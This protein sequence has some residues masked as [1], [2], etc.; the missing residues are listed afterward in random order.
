MI[1]EIES[2]RPSCRPSLDY[3]EGKVLR[4]VAELVGY[5]NMDGTDRDAVYALFERF[6]RTR[7]AVR[8]MSFH[9]SVNPSAEDACT[10]D[11]VLSFVSGLMDHLGYGSQPYLV[12]RHFDIEREHYHVVSV[13][14]DRDGRKINNYYEKRR[15]SAY[16][17]DVAAQFRFT[18]AEKGERVS[19]KRSISA[20]STSPLAMRFNPRGEVASQLAAIYRE[21][22]TYGHSGFSQ[23]AAVLEGLG[24]RAELAGTSGGGNAVALRGLDAGGNPVT[25]AFMEDASGEPFHANHRARNAAA[26]DRVRSLVGFAFGV[27]RSEGHF[28]NILRGKGITVRISRTAEGTPFGAT[29]VDH[30]SRTVFKAS[31]LGGVFS[32]GMMKQALETGKWRVE[33]RGRSKVSNTRTNREK[34]RAEAVALR[35]IRAGTVARAL[36]PVGQ[37]AGASWSGRV[38]PDAERRRAD[39]DAGRAGSIGGDFEDRRYVEKL[40]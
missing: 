14:A 11:D 39:R 27:S 1:V 25:E 34:S 16:M 13:R 23:L 29:F 37:P 28:T 32:V 18:L 31:D 33:E 17:R 2:P 20:D 7:Y 9:A 24:V 21:A 10:E 15:A 38:K 30:V 6:E 26:K 35:N 5:A 36:R 12:Y 22:L 8:E 19:V 3:N 40:K 4:G